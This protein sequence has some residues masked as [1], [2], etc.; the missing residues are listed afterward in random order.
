M[1]PIRR[2][3]VTATIMAALFVI[4][5][6]ATIVATAMPQIAAS[7]GDLHL[8]AW[9]FSSFL[10]A[11][12]ATTVIFGKLA[13][14]Y[15]R[16]PVLL[17]GL[18]VFTVGSLLC[19]TAH[20][21]PALIAW[22]LVQGVGAGAI[23]PIAVTVV[24][25]LYP[26]AERGRVQGWLASI[27][28]VSSVL[29][30]L[31]G[32]LIVARL[33]WAWVF[34]INIPVCVLAGIGFRL[35]LREEART[36]PRAI[37]VAGAALFAIAIA[38]L[39]TALTEAGVP[40][41]RHVAVPVAVALFVASA[42]LFALRER[43]APDPMVD[44][45]LWGRRLL[46]TANLATLSSGMAIIGLTTFLPMYVQAVL[47]RSPLVAG[48]TLT[49][50]LFGWPVGATIGA[51]NFHRFG[52]RPTL[53]F[54]TSLLP[55]GA[56]CF[57]LLDPASSPL[58]AA[59]GSIVMGLGMGF[60]STSAIVMVQDSVGWAERGAATASN[61]FARNLGST[62]GAAVLGA[63]L[64]ADLSGAG[65]ATFDRVRRLLDGGAA[66][67]SDAPT[68]LLLAHALH[69][70]FD[71]VFALAVITLALGLAVPAV[72]FGARQR[73]AVVAGEG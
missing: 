48:F 16:R 14:L 63:L 53:L 1:T 66:N 32:A 42:I 39:M 57:V 47:G 46:A 70:T 40:E 21:M 49:A 73:P 62:L 33:G 4:A 31:A 7:L 23:Q 45:R 60:L 26:A 52:L 51:R 2:P 67:V 22:R 20:T 72:A 68:R 38:A 15:G 12:T 19:G 27:W 37:D 58:L 69:T 5:I 54:G 64:N 61:I 34:W 10:L 43:T 3:L 6:E 8:Y 36:G 35:F 17:A 55:I 59:A 24:G 28:G 65:T 13:D 11:Q 29:G 50:M 71:G 18:A 9:V 44:I 30:P 56:A 41:G 25:D